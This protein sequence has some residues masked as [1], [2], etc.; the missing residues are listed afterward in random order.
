[1]RLDEASRAANDLHV[2]PEQL[3]PH[4]VDLVP[5]H[6]LGT[7]RQVLDGDPV[8]DPVGRAVDV[9]LPDAR[10]IGHRFAERLAG[11]GALMNAPAA[12]VQEALDDGYPS[13]QLG[14]GDGRSLTGRAAAHDDD[15]VLLHRTPG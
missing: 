14:R 10:E 3:V 5:D 9:A 1:M 11:Y 2:V 8:L 12:H 4:D 15:V 13:T 6:S 7:E